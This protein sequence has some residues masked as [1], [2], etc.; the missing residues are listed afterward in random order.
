MV[1]EDELAAANPSMGDKVKTGI[2]GDTRLNFLETKTYALYRDMMVRKGTAPAQ[3]K[4]VRVIANELQRRF[5]FGLTEYS[6]E[7]MR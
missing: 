2:C 6:C 7:V 1:L 4:P 3:L 5:F